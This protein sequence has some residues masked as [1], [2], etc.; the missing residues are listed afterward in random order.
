MQRW[1]KCKE[2]PK[3]PIEPIKPIKLYFGYRLS[4]IAYSP[5]STI[6]TI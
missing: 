1:G 5:Y 3:E 2:R 4:P 6:K